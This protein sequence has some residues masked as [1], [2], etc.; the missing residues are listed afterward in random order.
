MPPDAE[1]IVTRLRFD[2]RHASET[3]AES[4]IRKSRERREAAT[5][6]ETLRNEIKELRFRLKNEGEFSPGD[7]R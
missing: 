4:A 5:M 1:D 3:E 6:I 2:G 7:D